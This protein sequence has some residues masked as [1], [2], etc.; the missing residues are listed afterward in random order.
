MTSSVSNGASGVSRFQVQGNVLKVTSRFDPR[1]QSRAGMELL[2][3]VSGLAA[4]SGSPEVVLDVSDTSAI[5]SMMIG[6]LIE[7]GDLAGRAGKKLKIRLKAGACDRLQEL[8]L[9]A[10]F[11]SPL[12]ADGVWEEVELMPGA[13]EPGLE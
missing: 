11:S 7:A 1:Y 4:E 13:S 10:L 3:I 5:P 8:G 9:S 6:M 12:R 2:N